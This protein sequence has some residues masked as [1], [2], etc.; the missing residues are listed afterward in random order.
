[1]NGSIFTKRNTNIAKGIAVLMLLF[2]HLFLYQKEG[3]IDISVGSH[4]IS[5]MLSV[6][7]K[8]CVA[9]F[10]VLSGFGLYESNKRFKKLEILKFYKKAYLKLYKSYWLIW[11]IFVPVGIFVFGRSIE[12]VW[13]GGIE[14]NYTHL[15]LNIVGLHYI[16]LDY[17]YNPTWWFMTLILLLYL[18]F[19]LIR[20]L[21]NRNSHLILG[22]SF[23]L[24]HLTY[25]IINVRLPGF[26]VAELLML[27]MCPFVMGMYISKYNLFNRFIELNTPSVIRIGINL[28]ICMVLSTL[29]FTN[30]IIGGGTRTD[31]IFGVAIILLSID[32]IPYIGE[33]FSSLLQMFGKHSFLIFL[34][35]NFIYEFYFESIVYAPR[36][37]ILIFMWLALICLTLAL[38][39]NKM[40]LLLSQMYKSFTFR[41]RFRILGFYNKKQI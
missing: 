35:H 6:C 27:W 11:I 18:L 34:F 22:I 37:P 30:F 12:E 24:A 15:A 20:Y 21:M 5:S 1:M 4:S 36:V 31:A 8:G 28:F 29:K 25:F 39:I 10:L 23:I 38:I 33:R 40:T 13:N 19:P 3:I 32:L 9:I 17:G 41:E 14:Y 26:G 7:L 2:H 16:F